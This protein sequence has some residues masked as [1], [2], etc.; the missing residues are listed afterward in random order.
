MDNIGVIYNESGFFG[1]LAPEWMVINCG[2][3]QADEWLRTLYIPLV[4]PFVRME[5]EENDGE[6]T[7]AVPFSA[8]TRHADR[9]AQIGV[10]LPTVTAFVRKYTEHT[11]CG[12]IRRLIIRIM[13][14]EEA[15]QLDIRER[16]MGNV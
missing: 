10:H 9:P 6:A 8:Y 12:Q 15:L 4:G 3:L 5:M 16:L 13:D 1:E 7:V 14:A 11:D 2:G